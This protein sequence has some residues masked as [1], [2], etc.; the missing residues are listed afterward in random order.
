MRSTGLPNKVLAA[1]YHT[2]LPDEKLLAEEFAKTRRE[3]EAQHPILLDGGD[4][5]PD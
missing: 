4:R 2:V 1:D 3:W 5:S